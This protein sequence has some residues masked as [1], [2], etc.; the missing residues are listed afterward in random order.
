MCVCVCV[1]FICVSSCV[2]VE[3]D[4][5]SSLLNVQ[6]MYV[7]YVHYSSY[8]QCSL[9]VCVCMCVGKFALC[10]TCVSYKKKQLFSSISNL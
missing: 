9:Y 5:K 3:E 7:Q 10:N 4:F 1:L 2:H 8:R 6:Y